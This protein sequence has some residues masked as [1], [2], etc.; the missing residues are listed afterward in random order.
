MSL[1]TIPQ[2]YNLLMSDQFLNGLRSHM[3]KRFKKEK[4]YKL[5]TGPSLLSPNTFEIP[6]LLWPGI[7]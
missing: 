2:K 4:G 7:H 5:K 6:K 1:F 3:R